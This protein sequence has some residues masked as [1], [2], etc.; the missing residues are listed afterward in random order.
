MKGSYVFGIKK[1]SNKNSFVTSALLLRD[2]RYPLKN[3]VSPEGFIKR[4][5]RI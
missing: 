2:V 4:E 1:V 3:W 5:R